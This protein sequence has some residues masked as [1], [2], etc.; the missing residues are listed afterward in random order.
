MRNFSFPLTLTFLSC[1]AAGTSVSL[2][3]SGSRGAPGPNNPAFELQPQPNLVSTQG[4]LTEFP[5]GSSQSFNAAPVQSY[6][7]FAQGYDVYQ[8]VVSPPATP[9]KPKPNPAAKAYKGVYYANDF[10][11]LTDS[12]D[13]PV[14]FGDNWKN[15]AVGRQGRL[16]IGGEVRYRFMNE[17]GL[18]QRAG[19][20]RFQ[21][22]SNQFGLGRIRLFANY[23]VNDRVRVYAEG[24]H[25][26]VVH[27]NEEYIPRGI[28]QNFGDIQNLFLDVRVSDST[29][30][31]VGRQELLYGNQRLVS[32][33]DWANVRRT[34]DG[35]RTLSKWG[36]WSMDAFWTQPVNVLADELDESD[37]NSDFYGTYITYSGFERDSLELYYLGFDSDENFNVDT[38]GTRIYG[39][40]GVWD[41]EVEAAIQ[42]G[43]QEQLGQNHESYFVTAGIGRK[44]KDLAWTPS[45]WFYY[46]FASGDDPST[47][48]TFERFNQLFPLGHKYLG[49]IDAVQRANIA[50]PNIQLKL[51]PTKKI[52]L[53][54]WYHNFSAAETADGIASFGGTPAQDLSSDAFGNELDLLANINVDPRTNVVLGYSRFWTGSR[55]IG[56]EDADF[57]YVQLTKRF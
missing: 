20:T 50:A 24:I 13:G 35:V 32:P 44:F 38:F 26:S 43:T 46:D 53:L 48:E 4:T 45:L 19:F 31:R 37:S 30:V 29:V 47:P 18:G 15:I 36:D 28:D 14:Y 55:I 6:Q 8:P 27:S 52:S 56:G 9:P 2:A 39:N 23:E 41:Y 42:T 22:T 7:P 5:G 54:A 1:I 10:S 51:N 21:D 3:Q 40:R 49:F 17:Q 57:Y 33:L 34:F 12:Y 11:Y 16:S 25:S